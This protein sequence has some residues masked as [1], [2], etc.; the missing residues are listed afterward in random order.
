V[1]FVTVSFFFARLSEREDV[2]GLCGLSQQ[3]RR[4]PEAA[5]SARRPFPAR[6]GIA[7]KCC[8]FSF[9]LRFC[10]DVVSLV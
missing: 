6:P 3:A 4:C 9:G 10:S 1:C 5:P 7:L 8:H 2:F